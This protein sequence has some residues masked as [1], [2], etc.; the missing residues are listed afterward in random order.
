[1]CNVINLEIIMLI[2]IYLCYLFN[3]G[4]VDNVFIWVNGIPTCTPGKIKF[5]L[6]K[7]RPGK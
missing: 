6:E 2:H 7:Y 3:K 5:P 1:M 4:R